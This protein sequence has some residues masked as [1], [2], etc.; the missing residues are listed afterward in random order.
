MGWGTM[1]LL[2]ILSFG[3]TS[4]TCLGFAPVQFLD[5][6]ANGTSLGGM[7]LMGEGGIVLIGHQMLSKAIGNRL[8]SKLDRVKVHRAWL[9]SERSKASWAH[10]E[11]GEL[12]YTKRIDALEQ[13]QTDL[14]K[15]TKMR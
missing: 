13:L 9:I 10:D 7:F 6:M 8:T 5:H 4:A 3:G 15:Q 11:D 2:T 1:D 14:E 12:V